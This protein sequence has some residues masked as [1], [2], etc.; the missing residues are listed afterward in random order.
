MLSR[1]SADNG[2]DAFNR[3][4]VEAKETPLQGGPFKL[5]LAALHAIQS[6]FPVDS[7]PIR[8][9]LITARGAPTHE[10]VIRTL[11]NWGIRIDE[12]LFLGGMEKG[13]FPNYQT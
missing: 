13:A 6:E 5:F 1:N 4:E 10:R 11:R 3:N 12:A 8:T 7:S 2:L 9:A